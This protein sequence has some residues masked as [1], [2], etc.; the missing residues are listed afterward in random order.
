MK[1][2]FWT[3]ATK[4][5]QKFKPVM[6]KKQNLKI[7]KELQ[8]LHPLKNGERLY[9]SYQI[10]KLAA[11]FAILTIG[12]VSVIILR[13]CSRIEEDLTEGAQ[14]KRNEWGAGDYE[15]TLRAKTEEWDRK[16]PFLVKERKLTEE[17]LDELLERL[18]QELPELIKGNNKD[19]KHVTDDLNLPSSVKGYPFRLTWSSADNE[20][21]DSK[22]KINRTGITEECK[23]VVLTVVIDYEEQKTSFTYEV[24][25]LPEVLD[26]EESFFRLLKEELQVS[27]IKEETSE[28]ITLPENLYGKQIKWEVV[29]PDKSILL[30]L[31]SVLGCVMICRG[32]DNNLKKCCDKRSKQLLLDY[33]GFVSKL[34][35]YLSA[36]LNVKN[37]FLK[38]TAE[39]GSA[40][41]GKSYLY[42]EMKIACYQ[43]ENGMME[44]QVYQEFGKRCGQMRYRRLS[45]LLSVHLKQGN[46]QLLMLLEREADSALE[47]RR[48]TARK[49][50]EEAGTKLLLPMMLMLIVV[51]FLILLPVCFDFGTV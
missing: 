50:G 12:F 11:V 1:N 17:E 6:R 16:I 18:Q 23:Q 15:V 47:E 46:D 42:E 34:R 36:G 39:Y 4:V 43:L 5:Y 32:M 37:A 9:D 7:W 2:P 33:S 19:L 14:L 38:M 44:E 29:K 41:S 35:L 49:A 45:F 27:D 26:K 8:Q 13:L 30:L 51:M 21:I 48:N 20:R 3:L 10:K 31:V 25:L 28:I 24:T 22:G 40:Q